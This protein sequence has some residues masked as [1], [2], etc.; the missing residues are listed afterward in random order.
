MMS[1]MV[2]RLCIRI[3]MQRYDG[4]GFGSYLSLPTYLPTY[5]TYIHTHLG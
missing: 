2:G 4:A 3:G 1:I 5:L